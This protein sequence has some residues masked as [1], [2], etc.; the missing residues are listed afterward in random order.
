MFS[1]EPNRNVSM[2]L[3]YFCDSLNEREMGGTMRKIEGMRSSSSMFHSR[4]GNIVYVK[5][6]REGGDGGQKLMRNQFLSLLEC[7]CFLFG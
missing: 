2:L 7:V 5:R 1:Y 6:E 4:Y 3:F